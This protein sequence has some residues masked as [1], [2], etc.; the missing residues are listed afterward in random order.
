[1]ARTWPVEPGAD[2][3]TASHLPYDQI[4]VVTITLKGTSLHVRTLSTREYLAFLLGRR[5]S[6]FLQWPSWGEVKVDWRAHSIGWIDGGE[7]VGAGL[8]LYRRPP[9]FERSLAY[10]PEGPV[11]DRYASKAA[12]WLDPMV[13]HLR[14]EN[15]FT[16]RMGPP[17]VIRR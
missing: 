10:L 17:V 12:S 14:S 16:V 7:L 9:G 1:M 2:V 3:S 6:S 11:L 5:A 13:E 15:P 8:V 4:Q